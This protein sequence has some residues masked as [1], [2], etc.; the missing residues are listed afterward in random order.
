MEVELLL[1]K[2]YNYIP[3]DIAHSS[4][5][6]ALAL[7]EIVKSA[8][9]RSLVIGISTQLASENKI[10]IKLYPIGNNKEDKEIFKKA[11]ELLMDYIQIK[12]EL[13]KAWIGIA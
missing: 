11:E 2:P 1:N 3:K 8:F 10:L 12:K 6:L 5:D 9:G 13:Q 7:Q 4:I